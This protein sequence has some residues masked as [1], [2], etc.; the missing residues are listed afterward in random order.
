MHADTFLDCYRPR[1]LLFKEFFGAQIAAVKLKTIFP[2]TVVGPLV[3]TAP[4]LLVEDVDSLVDSLRR[5]GLPP[6][7]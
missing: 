2:D 1:L 5:Q 4:S 7:Y 6:S 3:Q